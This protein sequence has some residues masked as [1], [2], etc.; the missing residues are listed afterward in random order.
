MIIIHKPN[1]SRQLKQ[2]IELI[3]LDKPSASMKFKNELKES[4]NLLPD[5]PLKYRKSIYFDNENIRDMIYK[6]YTIIYR[7]KPRKNEI[8]ILRIFNRNKPTS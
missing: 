2:I 3:A 8:E 5:H 1:F 4:I 7:L 6:K